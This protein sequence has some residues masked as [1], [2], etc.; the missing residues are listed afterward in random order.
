MANYVKYITLDH[1]IRT[2]CRQARFGYLHRWGEFNAWAREALLELELSRFK[3]RGSQYMELPVDGG[4]VFIPD[5]VSS[6]TGVG[7]EV[8]GHIQWLRYD[9]NM[10]D[11]PGGCGGFESTLPENPDL[12]SVRG[13]GQVPMIYTGGVNSWFGINAYLPGMNR[14][15]SIYGYYKI[16]PAEGYI[17]LDADSDHGSVVIEC[18]APALKPNTVTWVPELVVNYIT[19]YITYKDIEHSAYDDTKMRPVVDRA[20]MVW[21]AEK[22]KLNNRDCAPPP[23]ELWAAACL[24][25]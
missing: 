20:K 8:G 25:G 13:H 18:I 5:S 24:W 17:I 4:R 14:N 12:P 1:V 10:I 2:K 3:L 23:A 22:Q 11:L 9:P 15:K 21:L 7:I 6:I 19:S 16:F